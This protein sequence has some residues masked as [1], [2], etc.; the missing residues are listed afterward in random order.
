MAKA[1]EKIPVGYY[2]ASTGTVLPSDNDPLM[3]QMSKT[4]QEVGDGN[5]ASYTERLGN[6]VQK[7]SLHLEGQFALD[8]K[9]RGGKRLWQP[10]YCR[11]K[12]KELYLAQGIK[13]K[14]EDKAKAKTKNGSKKAK[15]KSEETNSG[16]Q[17][18][19]A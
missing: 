18:A 9:Q 8:K 5:T 11:E 19:L 15:G 3:M 16:L 4:R 13:S 14:E 10:I 1:K 2:C 6:R 12:F 7:F 17:E